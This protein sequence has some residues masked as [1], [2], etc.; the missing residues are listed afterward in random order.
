MEFIQFHPTCLYH[1]QERSFLITE[2]HARRGRALRSKLPDGTRF[3]P[4]HDA[5]VELAPRDIVARAIDFEMKK[6]GLDHVWLDAT[7]PGR[8][9][10][11]GALPDHPRAL[12]GAGHRHRAPADPGG[13][14]RALH[15]R[16]RRHRSATA[17]PTCRACTR[18]AR[19][20]TP[21][22]TAPTGWRATRCS[23]AWC[24]AAPAPRDILQSTPRPRRRRCLPW[25][26]SQVEDADEQV[27]IAHNWD[28]LRLLMWNYVGI[29][30]TTKR[31][32]RALHR[33]KL[34]QSRDRRLL[35]QLPRQPRPAGAAQPGRL[36]RADRA[37]GADAPREPRPALQPRLSQTPAG[38]P[39]HRAGT[40]PAHAAPRR[41]ALSSAITRIEKS[42]ARHVLGQLADRDAV[43][44]GGGDRRATA[45]ADAAG[46]FEQRA[47]RLPSPRPR[48]SA[49]QVKLS[50][51]TLVAPRPAPRAAGRAFRPRSGSRR[52]RSAPA[53]CAAPARRR[54][55]RRCGSP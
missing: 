46:R 50:S 11:E 48:A 38:E 22:C 31:L 27:V 28:E 43:D 5:R 40:R 47:R 52:R 24:S 6:H 36:R 14:G 33:I 21:G 19:P 25:D 26:E 4:A 54:R 1:P 32:E 53:R 45:R 42:T 34:L 16:R 9:V 49:A 12:P 44:A 18:W 3:M 51:S 7:P 29:V 15:L 39:A 35:R 41:Y 37:L 13:A 23:S 10:P 17:A 8:G 55:P 30:R 2:A 20:P